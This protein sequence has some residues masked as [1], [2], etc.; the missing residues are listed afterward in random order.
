MPYLLEMKL[1]YSIKQTVKMQA[2]V[3]NEAI[4]FYLS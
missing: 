4:Y 1:N 3:T 2:S